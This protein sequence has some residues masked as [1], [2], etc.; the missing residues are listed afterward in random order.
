[1]DKITGMELT[2]EVPPKVLQIYEAVRELISQG[3]DFGSISVATITGKAGIGKGTAYEYFESKDEIVACALLYYIK[4][5][6]EDLNQVLLEKES[7]Q[8]QINY[9]LDEM[10]KGS[11][12][13]Y[14]FIRFIHVMTSGSGYCGLL[15][16]KMK[17]EPFARFLP[18][19]MFQGVI[20]RAMDKGEIRD[21]IP[22]GYVIY[23]ITSRLL[24][25]MFSLSTK[26]CLRVQ[27]TPT[28]SYVYQCI[29]D[30]LCAKK[31]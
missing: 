29:M 17:L 1:M 18:E 10:E 4:K 21:D 26:D 5:C 24:T 23:S 14:S 25:Y 15:H 22:T 12:Q 27:S 7:I 28:R 19:E 16:E 31:A 9:L 11:R 30:E 8:E 13:Q 20:Q 2:H 3:E 6:V